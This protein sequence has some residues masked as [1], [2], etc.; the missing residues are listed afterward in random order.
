MHAPICTHSLAWFEAPT[1]IRPLHPLSLSHTPLLF[2]RLYMNVVLS[3]MVLF[4]LANCT[5][6]A[7]LSGGDVG[8]SPSIWRQN[9]LQVEPLA[10]ADQELSNEP[11]NDV[12]A[13]PV[14]EI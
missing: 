12:L 13:S 3:E 11:N 4:F 9:P 7:Q 2:M 6:P 8:F 5:F 1:K 10:R 14:P